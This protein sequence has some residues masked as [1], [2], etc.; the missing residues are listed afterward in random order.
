MLDESHI[1]LQRARGRGRLHFGCKEDRTVL[2]DLHQSG[3]LKLMLP[4][5]HHPVPDAVMINTAGGLTGGDRLDLDIGLDAGAKLRVATQTAERIY[6]ST[7]DTAHVKLRFD[8]DA[9]AALDWLAQETILFDGGRVDRSI[10]VDM[11][12]SASLLLVEPIVLGRLAMGETV[13]SGL[14]HDHWRVKRAGKLC[15]ADET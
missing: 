1:S 15:F 4:R 2:R 5:N 10:E 7:G 3:C 13:H 6:K 12:A 8:L 11:D 9:Q 14:L